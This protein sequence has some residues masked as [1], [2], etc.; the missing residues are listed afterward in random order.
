MEPME[1]ADVLRGLT[2]ASSHPALTVGEPRSPKEIVS[3]ILDGIRTPTDAVTPMLML[4]LLRT[5]LLPYRKLLF[6]VLGFQFV[7]TIMTLLLPTLN[8]DIINKGVVAGDT[9]YILRLGGDHARRHARAGRV[10][11]HRDLLRCARR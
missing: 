9:D 3:V 10:R 1:A 4:K 6:A 11:D 5:Y 8:A 7:Q 2:I